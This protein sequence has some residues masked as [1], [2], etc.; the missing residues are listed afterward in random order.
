MGPLIASTTN[1][2]VAITVWSETYV[3]FSEQKAA[4]LT[5]ESIC[6]E[7]HIDFLEIRKNGVYWP[8]WNE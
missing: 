2:P 6:I 4:H 8:H 5:N 7:N 1:L 3:L